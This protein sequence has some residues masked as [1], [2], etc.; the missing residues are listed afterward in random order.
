MF[1]LALCGCDCCGCPALRGP[2]VCLPSHL[3]TLSRAPWLEAGGR[4]APKAAAR[5]GHGT[6]RRNFHHLETGAGTGLGPWGWVQEEQP[7]RADRTAYRPQPLTPHRLH[8]WMSRPG[9]RLADS[10]GASCRLSHSVL[11]W[12]MERGLWGPFIM[13]LTLFNGG[14]HP[15]DLI[16]P[17][18]ITLGI[19]VS[20]GFGRKIFSLLQ[21]HQ[22]GRRMELVCK[23]DILGGAL[24]IRWRQLWEGWC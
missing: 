11:P 14:L 13:A 18:T 23:G 17:N 4:S 22:E 24:G 1:P 15:H 12:Q 7:K 10:G 3:R 16:T 5:R 2:A 21:N 9:A 19:I 8:G 6:R 20:T